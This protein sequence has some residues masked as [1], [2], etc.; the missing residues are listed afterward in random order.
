MYLGS[1]LF[2]G[3]LDILLQSLVSVCFCAGQLMVIHCL[4]R[5]SELKEKSQLFC[6]L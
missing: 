6:W 4:E 1:A 3:F 5:K 2:N